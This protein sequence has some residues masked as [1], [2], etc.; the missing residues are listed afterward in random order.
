MK[1]RGDAIQQ[2][3]LE[4]AA[5]IASLAQDTN[6]FSD[7][8][9]TVDVLT[10]DRHLLGSRRPAGPRRAIHAQV[11]RIQLRLP[12][13]HGSVFHGPSKFPAEDTKVPGNRTR[14]DRAI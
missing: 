3:Q 5:A 10:G 11:R 14:D 1:G 13:P 7:A 4:Q 12:V 8:G 6:D 9:L 2:T